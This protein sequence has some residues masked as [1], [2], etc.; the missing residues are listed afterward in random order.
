MKNSPTSSALANNLL[1]A[2]HRTAFG[3]DFVGGCTRNE[4]AFTL[5]PHK[6]SCVDIR[7]IV[8][9]CSYRKFFISFFVQG[10]AL[11]KFN[12]PKPCDFLWQ[13][14]CF[15]CFFAHEAGYIEIN[16]SPIGGYACYAFDSYRT[17]ST[18]PP[19]W[20]DDVRFYWA[21]ILEYLDNYTALH[22]NVTLPHPCHKIHPTA[23][24]MDGT[25]LFYATRH[26]ST[27]DFH[28]QALWQ[29][30]L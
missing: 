13:D 21:D 4:T 22:F 6:P 2:S 30:L 9:H 15:E 12:A 10:K 26:A 14:T 20:A 25:P 11:P 16:A 18:I 28:N 27:P 23:I 3:A 8:S 17:P 1:F 24:I 19:I 7:C 29:F 5:S